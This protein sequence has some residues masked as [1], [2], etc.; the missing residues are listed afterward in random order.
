MD[1]AAKV[2]WHIE[3]DPLEEVALRQ[4]KFRVKELV[5]ALGI[6]VADTLCV[7]DVAS[8]LP[9]DTLPNDCVIKPNHASGW[10]IL[11]KNGQY[12]KFGT[13]QFVLDETGALLPRSDIF[14]HE[15]TEREVVDQCD[16]WLHTRY[17]VRESS[18]HL[19]S[20]V[21]LVEAMITPAAEGELMDYRFYTFSG[22][23]RAISVGSPT[24]RRKKRN[25]FFTPEWEM[26]PLTS[27][28][29]ALPEPLPTAPA[30]LSE[31]LDAAAVLG[32]GIDFVRIDL[33]EANS[34]VV[35]GEFTFYPHAG[36]PDTPTSCDRFNMWLAEG[37]PLRPLEIHTQ[38]S[39]SPS[40]RRAM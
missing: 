31:M 36:D 19:I 29:E 24:Y 26:I 38:R 32:A 15:L 35:F 30:R 13:Q 22:T 11:R 25:V 18:Y 17:S 34:G 21:I 37:W 5:A 1:F 10:A 3:H 7:T 27:Y 9:F 14:R 20:P 2:R 8:S 28:S 12:F 6:R 16:A 39:S 33:Y 4:D 23:V 40:L